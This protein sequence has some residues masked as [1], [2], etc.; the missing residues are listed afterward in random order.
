AMIFLNTL[1]AALAIYPLS[2]RGAIADREALRRLTGACLLLTLILALPLSL[3][4]IAAAGA[5]A[6]PT[7]GILAVI[8]LLLWQCQETLRRAMMAHGGQQRCIPGDIVS[9]LGQ[10]IAVFAFTYTHSLTIGRAFAIMGLTSAAAVAVQ[11]IQVGP[12]F[13][14]LRI[15]RQ[16]A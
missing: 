16:T 8:A 6:A 12:R 1:Q 11:T 5:V 3:G 2:V 13:G 7:I 14:S 10:A 9:Y 15:L 4:L